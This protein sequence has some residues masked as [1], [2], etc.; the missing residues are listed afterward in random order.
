MRKVAFDKKEAVVAVQNYLTNGSD[1][2]VIINA[3]DKTLEVVMSRHYSAYRYLMDD[4]KVLIYIKVFSILPMYNPNK[5]IF[6]WLY[7]IARNE[8]HNRKYHLDKD[9][10]LLYLDDITPPE[11]DD[12]EEISAE[13]EGNE[14]VL[15]IVDTYFPITRFIL[16]DSV[17]DY[18]SLLYDLRSSSRESSIFKTEDDVF[19]FT[20]FASFYT[21]SE[22]FLEL[23]AYWKLF[24]QITDFDLLFAAFTAIRPK[25]PNIKNVKKM[26]DDYRLMMKKKN[27]EHILCEVI[28]E[29][30]EP[31]SEKIANL[32]Q[33]EGYTL[34][35]VL[36]CME[37]EKIVDARMFGK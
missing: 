9:K 29:A 10:C 3:I 24:P 31:L 28:P 35:D 12:V 11:E 21:K 20:I 26:I 4:F 19:Q 22:S 13:A 36:M 7:S 1:S 2:S 34:K 17:M 5:D 27:R 23:Y 15:D 8:V 25:L 16:G 14:G 32:Y 33:K 18:L 37:G 6:T 30:L